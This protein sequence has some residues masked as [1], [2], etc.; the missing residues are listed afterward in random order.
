MSLYKVKS[1]NHTRMS[2]TWRILLSVLFGLIILFAIIGWVYLFI[3]YVSTTDPIPMNTMIV[4]GLVPAVLLAIC[5]I[6]WVWTSIR[7]FQHLNNFIKDQ[8]RL[9][10]IQEEPAIN[11]TNTTNSA[12]ISDINIPNISS[13]ELTPLRDRSRSSSNTR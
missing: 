8:K 4:L 3:V 9:S 2:I 7:T 1:L 11:T 13:S 10:T 6:P 12:D 5:F